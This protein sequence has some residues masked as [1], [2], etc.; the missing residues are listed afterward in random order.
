MGRVGIKRVLVTG[1]EGYIGAV[2]APL[3][4]TKGYD[5]VGI[6]TCFYSTT[7][8]AR[9]VLV[10]KDI[11]DI[12][13]ND[14]SGVDA[15]I[16]LAALS[17]DPVG[18]LDE[19]LTRDINYEA[20]VRLATLAKEAE[21][22]RFLFSSSCS[23]YGKTERGVV[24]EESP[25]APLTAYARSKIETERALK[26]LA[27]DH[28]TVGLLRNSTVYGYSPNFRSDLV[29]NN[30]VVDALTH[31]EIRVKSDGTPWRPLID[32]R[33]LSEIFVAF[34]AA[35]TTLI[36]GEIINIGFSENNLQV[37]DILNIVQSVIPNCKVVYTGEHGRDARSY[38]VD[39]TKFCKV[40]PT[41]RQQWPIQKS[42]ADM[43]SK[44]K[45]GASNVRV[46]VLERLMKAKKLDDRLYWSKNT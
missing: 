39:F 7:R 1:S 24:N 44:L 6:D 27:D 33:D 32:V 4:V 8:N 13:K 40:F 16:H 29:V 12:S 26:G 36:N 2:L 30:F 31:G 41:I 23:I 45:A 46:A 15:V 3:L 18:A 10:R 42:V 43:M 28:F 5:V 37:R 14:F 17:N 35:Q 34:L 21:V 11:R 25:V 9:N 22:K 20:S 38:R 19:K